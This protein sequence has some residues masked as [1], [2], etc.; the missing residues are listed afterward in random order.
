MQTMLNKLRLGVYAQR[1][2]L[3]VN[4]HKLEVMC[5]ISCTKYVPAPFHDGAQLPDTDSFK[6]LGMVYD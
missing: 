2:S 1:K 4:T 5:F 3:P 6:Y